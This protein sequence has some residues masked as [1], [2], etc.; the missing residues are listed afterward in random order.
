MLLKIPTSSAIT[1]KLI[2]VTVTGSPSQLWPVSSNTN[3][4][5]NKIINA[6]R[7]ECYL[8]KIGFVY[9]YQ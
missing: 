7:T 3:E 8:S 2:E 9:S 1:W 6:S 5:A 4:D